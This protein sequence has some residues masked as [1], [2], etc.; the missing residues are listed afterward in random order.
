MRKNIKL[1]GH[2]KAMLTGFKRGFSTCTPLYRAILW[3]TSSASSW[4]ELAKSHMGDSGTLE[5]YERI[6]IFFISISSSKS[7]VWMAPSHYQNQY[8][9]IAW[10]RHN[11]EDLPALQVLCEVVPHHKGPVMFA[12]ASIFIVILDQFFNRVAKR[13]MILD[14]MTLMWRSCNGIVPM[15]FHTTNSRTTDHLYWEIP[16]H[17]N[18]PPNEALVL[19][20]H[21]NAVWRIYVPVI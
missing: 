1:G 3:R 20:W 14:A 13:P 4:R 19:S 11:K 5:K 15:I 16:S 12:F 9:L 17:V 7:K 2:L 21:I 6:F 10:W 18:F 8:W